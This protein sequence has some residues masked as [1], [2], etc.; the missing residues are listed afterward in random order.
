MGYELLYIND[1]YRTTDIRIFKLDDKNVPF[2]TVKKLKIFHVIEWL[3]NSGLK[4]VR[5]N[6]FWKYFFK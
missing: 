5:R 1:M 3:N 4:E 6:L 2:I